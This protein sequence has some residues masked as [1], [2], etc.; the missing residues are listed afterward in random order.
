MSAILDFYDLCHFETCIN[1][2]LYLKF[3][4]FDRKHGFLSS[5]EAEIISFLQKKAA[6]VIF[7]ILGPSYDF[8]EVAPHPKLINRTL[9][10]GPRS[11]LL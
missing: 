6:I 3:P 9:R 11:M 5:I 7:D 10:L 4:T 8:F 1:G 2:F